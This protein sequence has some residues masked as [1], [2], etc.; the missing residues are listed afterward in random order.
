MAEASEGGEGR[1]RVDEEEEAENV[2]E[3]NKADFMELLEVSE[4]EWGLISE[5]VQ[6]DVKRAH[7]E[8]AKRYPNL[9]HNGGA[10]EP[11]EDLRATPCEDP[12]LEDH[13]A[14]ALRVLKN[15]GGWSHASTRRYLDI[16]KGL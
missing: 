11:G 15:A 3:R 5:N 7:G 10:E 2:F 6:E 16:M 12:L 4:E 1:A 8:V 13:A 14:R 9:I